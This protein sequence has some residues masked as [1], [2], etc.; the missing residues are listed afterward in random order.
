MLS[1][2]S[3]SEKTNTVWSPLYKVL[4]R[5]VKIIKAESITVAAQG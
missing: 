4:L 5:A 1:E 3:Q 2:I